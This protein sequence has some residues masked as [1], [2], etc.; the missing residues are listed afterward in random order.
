MCGGPGVFPVWSSLETSWTEWVRVSIPGRLLLL[1]RRT[2]LPDCWRGLCCWSS[3]VV[4]VWLELVLRLSWSVWGPATDLHARL[5]QTPFLTLNSITVC[6]TGKPSMFHPLNSG[7]VY[8]GYAS[9]EIGKLHFF[10]LNRMRVMGGNHISSQ[11]LSILIPIFF[12]CLQS[13]PPPPTPTPFFC[14]F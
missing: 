4:S 6:V 1:S 3:R 12:P 2:S 13:S 11:R 5:C 9:Y 7:N 10:F 8:H 14:D